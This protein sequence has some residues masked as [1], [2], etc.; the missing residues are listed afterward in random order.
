[1][2]YII[3]LALLVAG[4][5]DPKVEVS[6]GTDNTV[7]VD[8]T[9]PQLRQINGIIYVRKA[10]DEQTQECLAIDSSTV[11]SEVWSDIP[12]FD[13]ARTVEYTAEEIV[14]CE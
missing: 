12:V 7:K 1:M 9:K 6:G 13:S 4:C 14:N 10:L 5:G 2:K 3:V 8:S 11:Y